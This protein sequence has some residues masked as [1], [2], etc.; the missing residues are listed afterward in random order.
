MEAQRQS[1]ALM[2]KAMEEKEKAAREYAEGRAEAR[3][4]CGDLELLM[5]SAAG[6][7]QDYMMRTLRA[8]NGAAGRGEREVV[9]E[10]MAK[11]DV[12]WCFTMEWHEKLGQWSEG[13]GREVVAEWP[14]WRLYAWWGKEP[15]MKGIRPLQN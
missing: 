2:A 4:W 9:A 3:E 8:D 12:Q 14:E 15:E 10:E 13:Y 1:D 6:S 11:F 7:G 5:R